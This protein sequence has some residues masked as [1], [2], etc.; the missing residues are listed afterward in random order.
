M[1]KR[2]L[3]RR[4]CTKVDDGDMDG[5]VDACDRSKYVNDPIH[6]YISLDEQVLQF[7]D[8]PQFQ[9]LRHL[10]QLGSSYYVFPGGSHNRFEHCIG[11]SYLASKVVQGLA[12]RQPMLG[13]DK[14][15]IRC[16]ALAGLCHDLGH[17]PFSHVFDNE[18]IPRACPEATW[19]HEQGSEMMLHHAIDE[20]H[21]DIDDADVK[22]IKQLIRGTTK[23]VGD[24]KM[25][26][27]DIVANKRNGVDVDKFDYIQRDCYNVGVKSSYDFSRLMLN[28]RVIDDE[29]CYNHKEAYN[30]TEMFHT[31]YSLHKRVYSHRAAKAIEFMIIDAMLV[32]DPV[33]RFSK[34]IFNPHLFQ[35]L[36]DEVIRDIERSSVPELR[37]AQEIISR[38]HTRDIYKF[39]DEYILPPGSAAAIKACFDEATI[40][41]HR[42]DNDDFVEHDVLLDFSCIHYGMCKE[43]PVDHINFYTKYNTADKFS[44][45]TE[46]ISMC[47][48]TQYEEHIIRIFT[49]TPSKRSQI[50]RAARR[51]LE[52]LMS[53]AAA[54]S[55]DSSSAQ[56]TP[57]RGL[58]LPDNLALST[59]KRRR[60]DFAIM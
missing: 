48:P 57:N 52:T 21:I 32:A 6:G 54:C 4:G 56:L 14:R 8:T 15:D 38:I 25:F 27:F 34:A 23:P 59:S 36:T 1:N 31:R 60:L 33:L 42:S 19:S 37:E 44:I 12:Q 45:S 24:E 55:P 43:N 28:S 29:V 46:L 10:K 51:L 13:I 7:V 35:T 18:F 20:N 47:V 2:A 49:R 11:T 53:R 5:V 58:T 40:V 50:Q 22:F 17:G 3:L 9:R 16:V 30:L 41:G 26:L 39:V